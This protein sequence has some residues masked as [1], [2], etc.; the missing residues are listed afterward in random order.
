VTALDLTTR[1]LKRLDQDPAAPVYFTKAEVLNALNKGQRLFAFATLCLERSVS[2]TLTPGTAFYAGALTALDAAYLIPVRVTNSAGAKVL[3]ATIEQLHALDDQ[4]R[5][6]RGAATHYGCHG[7]DLLYVRGSGDTLTVTY[8]RMPATLVNDADA[9]EITDAYQPC[10]VDYAVARVRAKQGGQEF[11]KTKPYADR[12]LGAVK[13]AAAEVRRRFVRAGNDR[14]P[15][16]IAAFPLVE[17][18]R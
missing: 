16:E 6:N 4:W 15:F 13:A 11:A 3:P 10:L 18:R 8:A 1:T 17:A 7:F 14:P 5:S 9:V 12:F 2:L